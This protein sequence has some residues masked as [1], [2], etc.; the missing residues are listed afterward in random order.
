MLGKRLVMRILIFLVIIVVLVGF[1]GC[2]GQNSPTYPEERPSIAQS[3]PLLTD[4][5]QGHSLWGYF[6]LSFD[7]ENGTVSAIPVRNSEAHFNIAGFLTSPACQDC[8]TINIIS[9]DQSAKILTVNVLMKNM[10]KMTGYNVKGIILPKTAG[11]RLPEADGYTELWN[12]G[13]LHTRNPYMAYRKSISQRKFAPNASETVTYKIAYDTPQDYKKM[14]Y[15]VDV[16][17]PEVCTEPYQITVPTGLEFDEDPVNV[18]V[19][20]NDYQDDVEWVVIYPYP[21]QTGGFDQYLTMTNGSGNKWNI[22]ISNSNAAAA[23]IYTMWV[24]AKSADCD[25][26]NWQIM[27]VK[28]NA[29][30]IPLTDIEVRY[31]VAMDLDGWLPYYE[32]P[33]LGDVEF[34]Y[35]D[36]A[37]MKAQ[38]NQFWNKYGFNLVDDGSYTIM[39]DWGYYSLDDDSEV[40]AMHNAYGKKKNPN[41]LSMYFVQYLPPGDDTAFAIWPESVTSLAK[42]KNDDVF[43]VFCPNVWSWSDSMAHESG[44]AFGAFEDIYLLEPPS[45][46]CAQLKYDSPPWFTYLYCDDSAYYEGNLMYYSMGWSIN[47]YSLTNGQ[48]DFVTSFN[49]NY[50]NNW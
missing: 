26:V 30:P 24:E 41:A 40:L 25:I 49:A 5:Y 27:S 46:N 29:P 6:T 19:T 1:A 13:A 31:Y 43:I 38:A 22:S 11:T 36:A 33:F 44:H 20:V 9:N 16:S 50:P 45:Y 21:L 15:A 42:H 8:L 39:G 23:G 4:G 7:P 10:T 47:N 37:W 2:A 28:V 18:A 32:D 14:G 3:T 17:W 48:F 34:S 35:F 12:T